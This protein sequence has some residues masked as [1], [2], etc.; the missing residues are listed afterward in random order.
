[1]YIPNLILLFLNP[2]KYF[3][4]IWV[5]RLQSVDQCVIKLLLSLDSGK[6]NV[7]TW[8][9]NTGIFLDLNKKIVHF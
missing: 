1:M 5:K 3:L 4:R 2:L 6:K 7:K 8:N 9:D